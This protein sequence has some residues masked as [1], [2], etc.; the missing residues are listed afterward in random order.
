MN[1]LFIAALIYLKI[2]LFLAVFTF[3]YSIEAGQEEFVDPY[4]LGLRE[5]VG[6]TSLFLAWPM[7]LILGII[8][9]NSDE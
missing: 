2:G 7:W 3:W 6:I 9:R 4:D 5:I 8:F 1:C